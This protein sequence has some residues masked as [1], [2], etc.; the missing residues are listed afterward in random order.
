MPIVTVMKKDGIIR[1]C[2]DFKLTINQATQTEV[3]PLP[4][5][6]ELFASLSG[7]TVFSTLDLSRAYNR[8]LLDEKA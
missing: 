7:S 3:H 5:I 4:R 1:V 2:G 8:L 6:V